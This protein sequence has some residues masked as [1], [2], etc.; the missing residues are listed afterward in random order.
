M[1]VA[2]VVEGGGEEG[3]MGWCS[4]KGLE[5][6]V[7]C[8]SLTVTTTI[9]LLLLLLLEEMFAFPYLL[10]LLFHSLV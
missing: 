6:L 1:R 2:R 5:G 8:L 10:D 7:L 9:V 4:V 3:E